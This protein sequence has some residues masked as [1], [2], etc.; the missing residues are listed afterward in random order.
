MSKG[1]KPGTVPPENRREQILEEATRLFGERGYYGFGIRELAER[2]QLS[3]PGLFHHFASKEA[4]LLTLLED[5]D[6]AT[7]D[8]LAAQLGAN[9]GKGGAGIG[10]ERAHAM[11]GASARWNSA[12][13]ELMR[14]FTVIQAEAL[15]DAHPAHD[16]FLARQSAVIKSYAEFISPFVSD[17]GSAALHLVVTFDGL[18]REWLRSAQA[19]DFVAEVERAV[20]RILPLPLSEA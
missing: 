3:N 8:A 5:R 19:F 12:R 14:L 10:L 16:Y 17:A 13:P 9:A 15:N 1:R 18:Q 4:L 11:F 20:A 7:R 6:R 2:C